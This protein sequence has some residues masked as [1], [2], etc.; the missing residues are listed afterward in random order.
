LTFPPKPLCAADCEGICTVC[1]KVRR[2]GDCGCEV[3]EPGVRREKLDSVK[4]ER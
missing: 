3:K 4:K 1:G 2:D